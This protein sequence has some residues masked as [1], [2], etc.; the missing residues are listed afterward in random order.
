MLKQIAPIV[1]IA[2]LLFS[3]NEEQQ[4]S[5]ENEG[6]SDVPVQAVEQTALPL[7]PLEKLEYLYENCSHIDYVFYELP[8][9]MS[10]DDKG[11]IQRTLSHISTSVAPETAGCKAMGRIFFDV[12][13]ETILE[14]DLPGCC[15]ETRFTVSCHLFI[16]I[17]NKY[18]SKRYIESILK[19]G[20]H[21]SKLKIIRP[22][23]R[24]GDAIFKKSEQPRN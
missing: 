14:A 18:A 5:N 2:V 21:L 9:S 6:Q 15:L 22:Y 10:L 19:E 17:L 16:Y 8:F 4:Q 23:R 3:C 12:G 20:M 11:S 13:I 1:V 7:P 24:K